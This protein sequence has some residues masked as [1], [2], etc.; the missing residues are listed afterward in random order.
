[1]RF[2]SR[3]ALRRPYDHRDPRYLTYPQRIDALKIL[4]LR[5]RFVI[6]NVMFAVKC[7]R[8]E[9]SA[10]IADEIARRIITRRIQTRAPNLFDTTGLALGSRLKRILNFAN[11]YRRVIDLQHS[12][13]TN[14]Q[15]LKEYFMATRA[16]A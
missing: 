2:A 1:M 5:E 12:S 13:H 11:E 9:V 16:G 15:Q 6:A 14:R 4:T 7:A 8:G 3:C 10:P